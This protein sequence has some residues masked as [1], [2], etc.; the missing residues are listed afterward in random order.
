M[1]LA[2]FTL[3]AAARRYLWGK[4]HRLRNE[5]DRSPNTLTTGVTVACPTVDEGVTDWES[6]GPVVSDATS[7]LEEE[8]IV[9]TSDEVSV[10]VLGG[11]IV[12][13]G[14]V[15]V[16]RVVGPTD[17][18]SVVSVT[19]VGDEMLGSA[20]V[21]VTMSLVVPTGPAGEVVSG[22]GDREV[23]SCRLSQS[24]KGRSPLFDQYCESRSRPADA[25]LGYPRFSFS[26]MNK[27]D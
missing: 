4:H 12:G 24:A 25:P 11:D 16:A 26:F 8:T 27:Y 5:F 21:G 19:V 13:S 9:V 1:A 3:T 10:M 17:V 6:D 7:E 2:R 22:T 20:A 23:V 14:N 18:A 15:A